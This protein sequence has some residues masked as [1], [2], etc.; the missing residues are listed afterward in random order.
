[1]NPLTNNHSRIAELTLSADKDLS[2]GS[3]VALPR[4]TALTFEAAISDHLAALLTGSSA[5][6]IPASHPPFSTPASVVT[7][8][9]ARGSVT[10]E[11]ESLVNQSILNHSTPLPLL[12][13]IN[14]LLAEE[15]R[16]SQV[17][18]QIEQQHSPFNIPPPTELRE[19]A[20]VATPESGKEFDRAVTLYLKHVAELTAPS[21]VDLGRQILGDIRNG[22]LSMVDDHAT[23]ISWYV[24]LYFR[25]AQ[26]E[27][28]SFTAA[29]V[30]DTAV[31]RGWL[32]GNERPGIE[33]SLLSNESLATWHA[34]YGFKLLQDEFA[35]R[36]RLV[37]KL[38]TL[39]ED[40]ALTI[41]HNIL[42]A[43]VRLPCRN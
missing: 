38:A 26:P 24:G 20:V 39:A 1:M 14:E 22:A 18:Q 2:S 6:K 30:L 11:Q 27:M 28:H 17:L 32:S 42:D 33:A 12:S 4:Q 10:Q 29:A 25:P 5:S 21:S 15:A 41:P 40:A 13:Q 43:T 36:K 35:R 9:I 8:L 7:A 31:A 3:C 37:N 16:R 34:L 19:L 23:F